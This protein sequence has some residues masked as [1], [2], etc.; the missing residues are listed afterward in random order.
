[1]PSVKIELKKGETPEQA[2]ELLFKA[3]S[4]QRNGDTHAED[5]SD[6]AMADLLNLMLTLGDQEYALML[7]EINA[8][9]S[10]DFKNGHE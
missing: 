9:L 8:A 7:Q 5:F 4:S 10:E 1:M 3:I 6:P 2:E